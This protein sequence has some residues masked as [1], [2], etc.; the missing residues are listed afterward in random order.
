MPQS[1]YKVAS[2]DPG[3]VHRQGTYPRWCRGT[4]VPASA[5]RGNQ[6][7]VGQFGN[8]VNENDVGRLNVA[9]DQ[10]LLVKLLERAR[11]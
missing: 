3:P 6:A 2:R 1:Q 5:N 7:N 10:A 9:M 4:V 8:A 11:Q